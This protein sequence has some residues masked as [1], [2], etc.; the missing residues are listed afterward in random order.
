MK[1]VKYISLFFAV[2]LI[3]S[4]EKNEIVYKGSTSVSDIA[5]FQIHYVVP[6][7]SNAANYIYKI[8]INDVLYSNKTAPLSNYSAVP[9]A[10]T[11]FTANPGDVNIKLYKGTDSTLVYDQNTTLAAGK[12]NIFVHDFNQQPV[13]FDNGYP[14]E[15]NITTDTDSACYVKFYH[16][17]YET[18]GVPCSLKLQYQYQDLRTG[19]MVNVGQPVSFGETTGWQRIKVIK[20]PSEF[21]TQG[22]NNVTYKIKLV[23]ADGTIAGDLQVMNASSKYVS[24][25][26]AAKLQ[27]IG[28][29]YHHTLAGMRSAK[30]NASVFSFVAL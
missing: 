1:I 7:T 28:R 24:Y 5:E 16:F 3:V 14:Y 23:N 27:G 26:E 17:L 25:S 13:V 9:V 30:P 2:A 22:T 11:F 12:Q 29:R 6:V 4:C 8:K 19:E 10:G 18:D 20:K 21:N 15:S